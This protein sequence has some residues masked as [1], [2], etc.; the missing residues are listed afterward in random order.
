MQ[1]LVIENSLVISPVSL[2]CLKFAF[3]HCKSVQLAE[4]ED[5]QTS[6]DRETWLKQKKEYKLHKLC[7]EPNCFQKFQNKPVG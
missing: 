4:R 6:N 7:H 1:N 3:R 2:I 5:L